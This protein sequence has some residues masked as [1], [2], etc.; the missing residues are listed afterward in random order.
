[1]VQA[2]IALGADV[3]A[4]SADGRTALIDAVENNNLEVVRLLFEK[5]ADVTKRAI[6]RTALKIA[7]QKGR[8]EIAEILRAHG[9]KD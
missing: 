5:G 6:G 8:K 1:M 4:E 2:V 9:A 3:N 7:Q